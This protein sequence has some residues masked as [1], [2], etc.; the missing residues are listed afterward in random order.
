MLRDCYGCL[1]A[2][3]RDVLS[4]A[5]DLVVLMTTGHDATV[6][7]PNSSSAPVS[8]MGEEKGDRLSPLLVYRLDPWDGTH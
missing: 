2:G 7:I 1:I 3:G 4:A 6:Y 5:T 8:V